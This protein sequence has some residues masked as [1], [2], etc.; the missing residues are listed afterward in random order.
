M[1]IKNIM[2]TGSNG[3]IGRHLV[4]S[5]KMEKYNVMEVDIDKYDITNESSFKRIKMKPN[6][7]FHLAALTGIAD[8]IDN[9]ENAMRTNIQGTLN[10]L[11]FCR[12][13]KAKIVFLSSYIYGD[14]KYL[15]VDEKHP[16]N[17]VSPYSYTKYIGEQ[18]CEM[19]SRFYGLRCIIIRPSNVFGKGQKKGFLVPDVISKI[20]SNKKLTVKNPGK[21][22]DLIYIKDLITLLIKAMKYNKDK[23]TVLN[24][25]GG[26]SYTIK[27]VVD[28][29]LSVL[30]EKR[31]IKYMTKK[32]YMDVNDNYLNISKAVKCLN[33]VPEYPLLIGL[34]DYLK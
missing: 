4:E 3:F 19:Y 29:V 10:V 17:I 24:A 15:P 32:G 2:V 31:K 25:G 11:E 7:V 30:H 16:I 26:K 6:I 23:Y 34:K 13:N 20:D 22:R 28:A 27:Y 1:N 9:P 14:P 33:W 5:L 21:K 8:S 12:K 18:M